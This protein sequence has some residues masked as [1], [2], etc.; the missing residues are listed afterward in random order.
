MARLHFALP[1]AAA[2]ALLAA[3]WA[4]NSTAQEPDRPNPFSII[5]PTGAEIVAC[6]NT[7]S[8]LTTCTLS[9]MRDAVGYLVAVQAATNALGVIP[10]GVSELDFTGATSGTLTATT[11]AAPVDGQHLDI[12]TAAGFSSVT[13]TANAG[14]TIVGAVTSLGANASVRYTFQLSSNTWFRSR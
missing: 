12:F 3:G 13:L 5:S 4:F 1:V 7:S 11:A 9:Q 2:S 8:L 10:A 6:E 14:Q